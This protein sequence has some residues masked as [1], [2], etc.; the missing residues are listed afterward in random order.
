MR[1]ALLAM[2]T[3]HREIS[4]PGQIAQDICH[5]SRQLSS[6]IDRRLN[7]KIVYIPDSI[8]SALLVRADPKTSLLRQVVNLTDF[9]DQASAFQRRFRK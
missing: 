5:G 7:K 4:Q 3:H 1:L 2:A 9:P 6:G 8:A